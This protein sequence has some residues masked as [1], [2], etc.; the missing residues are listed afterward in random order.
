MISSKMFAAAKTSEYCLPT[1]DCNMGRKEITE[2]RKL[3]LSPSFDRSCGILEVKSPEK[4]VADAALS[5]SVDNTIV[6]RSCGILEV[7]SPEKVVAAVAL[8]SLVYWWHVN[9]ASLLHQVVRRTLGSPVT[10]TKL[11]P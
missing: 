5:S 4:V 2:E 9:M 8:S 3:P 7:K 11:L 6:D 10:D 1:A